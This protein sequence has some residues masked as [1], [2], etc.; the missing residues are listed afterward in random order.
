MKL[1]NEDLI[2]LAEVAQ[3]A[4]V[5]AGQMVAQTR[6]K[7]VE[8]KEGGAT[9]ASQVVTEID[10]AAEE[11]I[12]A[13]LSPTLE[14][15]ALGLLTEETPDDG[16]RL[17]A[18]YFWC[19]DPI[20]GT[21][22]FIEGRPGYSISIALVRRDAVPQI[23]VVYDPVEA[24]LYHAVAGNGL[25]RDGQPWRPES[26]PRRDELAVFV[27]SRFLKLENHDAAV[28][29]LDRVA[30]DMGL[31]GARIDVDSGAVMKACTVLDR[32]PACFFINPGPT[33][34]SLWDFAAIAC[35]FAEA[36]AIATDMGGGALDLNRADS[37]NMGHRGALF[38]SDEEVA[39]RIRQ[40][41][42]ATSEE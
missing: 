22:P 25:F 27:T 24:T 30:K 39:Q 41:F 17:T 35:L 7:N 19:I 18:D 4:A 31:I 37:A 29:G 8:H 33:G 42:D 15:Y 2:A 5:E 14:P 38:A 6:P 13:A 40:L 10:R 11:I 12:V 21:L 16:G 36:N 32:A 20:D 34:A 26:Q 3:R 28:S 9:L 23:G 1:S